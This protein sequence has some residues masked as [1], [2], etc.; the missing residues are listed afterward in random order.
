MIEL[1]QGDILQAEAEALV[2]TVNCVGIMG[3]GIALQFRKEYPENFDAYKKAC[4]REEV[5]PG[6]MLV[7]KLSH[8]HPPQLHHQ[9]SD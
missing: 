7:F 1:Q 4:A 5:A 8:L 3:R 6:K 9:L 2:N